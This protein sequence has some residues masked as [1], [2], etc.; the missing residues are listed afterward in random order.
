MTGIAGAAAAPFEAR[1]VSHGDAMRV[2]VSGEL[3]LDTGPRLVEL[4]S[5][6]LTGGTLSSLVVDL[7][8]TAF[9]DSSGLRA[10][11]DCRRAAI[12]N[13]ISYQLCVT[14]GPVTKLLQVA[15]VADYF[16]YAAPDGHDQP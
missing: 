11:L 5:G 1:L 10:L 3:D 16:A 7:M 4:V 15:G 14:P 13:G 2:V 12:G 9:V 8:A 6:T